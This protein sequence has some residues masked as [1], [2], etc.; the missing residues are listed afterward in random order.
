M[1]GKFIRILCLHW[2]RTKFYLYFTSNWSKKRNSLWKTRQ[3][4]EWIWLVTKVFFFF[5][6]QHQY[7]WQWK[8]Q[9][10]SHNICLHC[11]NVNIATHWIN[12]KILYKMYVSYFTT[13][14]LLSTCSFTFNVKHTHN[15]NLCTPYSIGSIWKASWCI[16]LERQ[17]N[18]LLVHMY[19]YNILNI[20][21]A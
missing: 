2:L 16:L 8:L 11:L 7:N 12:A 13:R 4:F 18:A 21:H 15:T 17:V 10:Q 3:S 6:I 1:L 14:T 9:A 5:L 19:K 20:T